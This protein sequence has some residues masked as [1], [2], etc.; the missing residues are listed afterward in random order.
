MDAPKFLIRDSEESK[1]PTD[2]A[3]DRLAELVK[4]YREYDTVI[5]GLE[6]QLKDNKEALR[7]IS[8]TEIPSIVNQYGLSE[9][10]LRDKSKVIVKEDASVSVPPEKKT[11]FEA[12]LLERNESDIIKLNISF[13]RMPQEKLD[14]LMEFLIGYDYDFEAER[15]VHPQ[16]LKKYFKDLL[17]IGEE[18]VEDGIAEGRYL[19]REDVE[20][21][22]NVF[23]FYTTKIK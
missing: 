12:F 3:L 5:D 18:D 11:A 7:N 20:H 23:T 6:A 15:G 21:I 8:Q 19:R 9:I 10:R 2:D 4:A 13:A 1:M 17:G 14:Q 16:T 22:A